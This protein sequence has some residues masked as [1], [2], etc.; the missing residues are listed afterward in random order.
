MY[1]RPAAHNER[2]CGRLLAE[3]GL[4]T[5]FDPLVQ[6]RGLAADGGVVAVAGVD[7]GVVGKLENLRA[8][9]FDDRVEGGEG[10]VA[11]GAG[12]AVEQGIAAEEYPVVRGV[13]DGRAWRMAGGVQGGEE[14]AVGKRE[15]LL[16]GDLFVADL[17]VGHLPEHVVAGV[18]EDGGV[19]ALGQLRGDGDVVV[20][21]VG[22]QYAQDLAVADGLDD[23]FGFVGCV[24]DVAGFVVADEPDVVVHIPLATVEG[25][26]AGRDNFVDMN[27]H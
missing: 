6:V 21:A 26:R 11:G 2:R 27:S 14:G 17:G 10:A 13:E 15:L 19:E 22:E 1:Y 24:D 25:E 12:A 5:A 3:I 9:R 23:G 18:Q 16:V 7:D 4:V 8:Q 20:V